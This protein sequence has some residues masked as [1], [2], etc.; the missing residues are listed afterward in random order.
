MR[1][2]KDYPPDTRTATLSACQYL[3]VFRLRGAMTKEGVTTRAGSDCGW[4]EI[5]GYFLWTGANNRKHPRK[6]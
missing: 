2:E 1:E 6:Q 5:F 3:I 4:I